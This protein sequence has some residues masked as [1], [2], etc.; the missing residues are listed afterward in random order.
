M[1]CSM[2]EVLS[3]ALE[4]QPREH[5]IAIDSV[6]KQHKNPNGMPEKQAI[7]LQDEEDTTIVPF[8]VQGHYLCTHIATEPTQAELD[9]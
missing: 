1:Q 8:E 4:F 6:L 2:R 7:Y 3:L 5:G 9:T